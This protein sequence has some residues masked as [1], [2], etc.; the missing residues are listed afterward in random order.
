M[1]SRDA[2]GPLDLSYVIGLVTGLLSIVL[3]RYLLVRKPFYLC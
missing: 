3:S 2:L 1:G